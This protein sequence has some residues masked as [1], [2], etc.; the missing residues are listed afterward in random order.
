MDY[1]DLHCD[2][3][4]RL[5][6][7]NER[8]ENAGGCINMR[9]AADLGRYAQVYALFVHDRLA[10]K[11][12][13]WQEYHRELSC[14]QR[15]EKLLGGALQI[16][17][18]GADLRAALEQGKRAAVL[19]VENGKALGGRLDRV[20]ELARD[21]VRLLTFTWFGENELGYGSGIGGPLKRFGFEVLRECRRVGIIPDISHLS[22]QGVADVFAA[23]DGV[24]I[25]THSNARAVTG[26]FRNLT[27]EM[28]A[29]LVRRKGLIGVNFCVSFLNKVQENASIADI[30]RHIQYFLAKG[31][32]DTLA[33]GSDFDGAHLPGELQT[34]RDVTKIYDQLSRDGVPEPVLRKIFFE[35]AYRFFERNLGGAV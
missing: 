35:N 3:V 5:C 34:L 9:Y 11:E 1:F 28:I 2:T 29:E 19:S 22:D 27:D 15:Q 17:R 4:L 23:D 7:Q 33:F 25:A 8:L 13:A 32:E 12:A 14:I 24:L 16:C 21:G 30:C 18:T 6:D 20:E 10:T 31:C 26:H